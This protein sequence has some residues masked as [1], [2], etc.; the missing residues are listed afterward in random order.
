M[1]KSWDAP[2][3]DELTT[4]VIEHHSALVHRLWHLSGQGHHLQLV[5][6]T[7]NTFTQSEREE[8]LL[9]ILQLVSCLMI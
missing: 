2:A 7:E 5:L 9:S 6:L 8:M 1:R 3:K 4:C